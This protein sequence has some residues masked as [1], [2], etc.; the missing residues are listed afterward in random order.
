MSEESFALYI[1]FP[2]SALLRISLTVVVGALL[3]GVVTVWE[4]TAVLHAGRIIA[5]HARINHLDD[6]T[7]QIQQ[8]PSSTRPEEPIT[9]PSTSTGKTTQERQQPWQ[10][11]PGRQINHALRR[12][13]S[14]SAQF[15]SNST[16]PF[17]TAQRAVKDQVA[18]MGRDMLRPIR[19]GATRAAPEAPGSDELTDGALSEPEQPRS[20]DSSAVPSSV[21]SAS[22]AEDPAS[23]A[24]QV[25]PSSAPPSING[26]DDVQTREHISN[27][28]ADEANDPST[29]ET[30]REV[31]CVSRCQ[32]LFKSMLPSA[33]PKPSATG[34]TSEKPLSKRDV[35]SLMKRG[36]SPLRRLL[37]TKS[38]GAA[39]SSTS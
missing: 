36:Q 35:F 27:E 1:V 16:R 30:R 5:S 9:Q 2:G 31:A 24:R 4:H 6:A 3:F 19:L 37:F 26:N 18:S 34:S 21:L 39:A 13:R 14:F 38:E 17:V 29:E 23:P 12:T 22:S 25:H 11:Y 33:R 7:K 8:T 15:L 32:N 28:G 10:T 20:Q